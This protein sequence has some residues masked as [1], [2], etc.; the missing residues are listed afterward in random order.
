MENPLS[1]TVC[2]SRSTAGPSGDF[3]AFSSSPSARRLKGL[4]SQGRLD[5][6]LA[7]VEGSTDISYSFLIFFFPVPPCGQPT[8]KVK[9]SLPAPTVE[10]R[11]TIPFH[12]VFCYPLLPTS[13]PPNWLLFSVWKGTLYDDH[14]QESRREGEDPVIQKPLHLI[15][16]TQRA[17]ACVAVLYS[18]CNSHFVE[19][20]TEAHNTKTS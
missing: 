9:A 1:S 14:M 19:G 17:T 7:S 20:K 8:G 11:P 16:H 12:A 18:L 5:Y 6:M 3:F 4:I 13:L 2:D 10:D 15:T